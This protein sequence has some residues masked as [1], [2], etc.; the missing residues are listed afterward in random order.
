M[1]AFA[2]TFLG[3]PG[4]SGTERCGGDVLVRYQHLGPRSAELPKLTPYIGTYLYGTR[5][6]DRG[7]VI[8][9][10]G[11]TQLMRYA[12]LFT[13]F[14]VVFAG[15]CESNGAEIRCIVDSRPA[16]PLLNCC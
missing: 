5:S 8:R 16:N 9:F 10:E 1:D 7:S 13:A 4:T 3:A 12:S 14:L 2:G 15:A 6:P 11:G